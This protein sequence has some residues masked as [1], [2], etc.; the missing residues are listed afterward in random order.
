MHITP[1]MHIYHAHA[2][3][4]LSAIDSC[5]Q[6]CI[7]NP[8]YTADTKVVIRRPDGSKFGSLT[9]YEAIILVFDAADK[10]S[11]EAVRAWA[12]ANADAAE[13]TEITLV[14]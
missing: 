3:M 14:R 4:P 6:W 1:K 13:A 8:Y 9:G 12:L 11:W 5:G 2:G 10:S 7:D